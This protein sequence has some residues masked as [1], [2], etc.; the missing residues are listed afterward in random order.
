MHSATRVNVFLP[1][2]FVQTLEEAY[3]ANWREQE[4][5]GRFVE[6]EGALFQRHWFQIVE[7]TPPDL[8]WF[9]Y[10]DLAASIKTTADFTAS[11][12]VALGEDGVIYVRDMIHGKWE[13]PDAKRIIMQSMIGEPGTEHAI[14]EALHGL[15]AISQL[16]REPAIVNVTLRGIRVDKDKVSRALPW[17]ARAEGGKVRLVRGNW[18]ADFL[19]EACSFP[20]GKHDDMIDSLSGGVQMITKPKRIIWLAGPG[21]TIALG[22]R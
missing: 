16:R 2:D 7:S 13:W 6:L 18:I 12:A 8:K 9:R 17:A 19:D 5:E 21:E 22:Q 3:T 15:A 1:A 20:H 11:A 14:E 4:L 10:W